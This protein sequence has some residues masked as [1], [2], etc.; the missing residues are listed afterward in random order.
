MTVD[1]RIHRVERAVVFMESRLFDPLSAADVARAAGGSV[2]ELH[3]LFSDVFGLPLMAYLRARRLTEAAAML[4]DPD[5]D[6]LE[7]ATRCGYGSQAAFTRA[8]RGRFGVPPGRFRRERPLTYREVRP[9]DL[10]T[11]QHRDA[12]ATAPT[13]RWVHR[14]LVLHGLE[15]P[16]DG[17]DPQAFLDVARA[18]R[19]RVGEAPAVGMVRPGPSSSALSYVVGVADPAPQDVT[20]VLPAGLYAVQVHDGAADRVIDTLS[21]LGDAW[22]TDLVEVAARPHAERFHL[23]DVDAPT[24]PIAFWMAVDPAT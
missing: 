4:A 22:H 2:S 23:R 12:L 6:V 21:F 9:A 18:L 11:L 3:R 10:G 5:V 19:D 17:R 7:V 24:L 8:F 14:D 13:M 1:A 15:A 20:F 16:V